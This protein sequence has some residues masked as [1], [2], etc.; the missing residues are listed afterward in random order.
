MTMMK[1]VVIVSA[2]RT[3]IGSFQGALAPLSAPK[4]G[5][6][7]IKEA[8]ERAGSPATPGRIGEVYMGCVLPAGIGQAPARQAAIGAGVPD[9][10]GAVTDQ[11]GLRLGPE[12]GRVRRATRSRPA[13]TTSSSRAAWSR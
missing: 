10:V 13:S 11:Q 5:A 3:P 12:G 9:K 7:A 1:D 8:L 4:L 6:I 2:A